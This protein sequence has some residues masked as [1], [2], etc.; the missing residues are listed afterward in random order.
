[1]GTAF[2]KR[3]ARRARLGLALPVVLLLLDHCSSADDPDADG[4]AEVEAGPEQVVDATTSDS[5]TRMTPLS[6]PGA[7]ATARGDVSIADGGPDATSISDSAD[8][9]DPASGDSGS[10]SSDAQPGSA[11]DSSFSDV[12]APDS[13]APDASAADASDAALPVLIGADGGLQILHDTVVDGVAS[14]RFFWIDS[15]GMKRSETFVASRPDLF[16]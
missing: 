5:T 11:L 15:N 13:S 14:D 12:F 16:A 9:S 8:S 4:S 3:L 10:S 6:S 7:G 2:M 1:M